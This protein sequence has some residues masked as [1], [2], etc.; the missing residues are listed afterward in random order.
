MIEVKHVTKTY[1]KKQ[2]AFRALDDVNFEIPDGASVAIIGKSGSGK[3]TLMHAMSGLDRPEQGEVVIDAGAARA[4][5]SGKSL[6]PAGVTQI[7]GRFGRGDPV[8]IHVR[9]GDILDV[10][11]WCYSSW[12]TKYVP[13]E[14]FRAFISTGE[15]PVISFSDTP[16]AV[17]H[18]AQGNPRILPVTEVFGDARL[19]QPARDLL[20]LVLMSECAQVGAPSHSAFSRAAAVAGRCRIVALPGALPE[21]LRRAAYDALLERVIAAQDSFFAPGDLAQSAGY[22]ARH[23]VVVGRGAELVDASSGL[24]TAP[25]IKDVDKIAAFLKAVAA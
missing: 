8:A 3:S 22:A 21:D 14:F 18:L 9:R 12:A 1:G 15:G 7:A 19:P 2:N 4:L 16:E 13:D 20:E 6:L 11:P 17:R 10:P 5:E 24:E 23:A 25:G